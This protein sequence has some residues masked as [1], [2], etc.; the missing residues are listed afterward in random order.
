MKRD[1]APALER[2]LGSN[3]QVDRLLIEKYERM[4]VDVKL[5][6]AH[7]INYLNA[8]DI[9]EYELAVTKLLVHEQ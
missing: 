8:T 4:L 7:L 1:F 9:M 6:N 5:F 3:L 2:F